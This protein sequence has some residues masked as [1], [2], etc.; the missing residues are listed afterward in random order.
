MPE[1]RPA[2][3]L[4]VDDTEPARYA[5]ART[6]QRAGF[7][8]VEAG[9]GEEALRQ[10]AEGGIDAVVLDI[11]LPDIS[12]LEVCRTIKRDHPDIM[13]LQLSAT[14]VSSGDRIKGLDS[15]AD[16]YLGQPVEPAELVATL[17]ALMRIRAAEAAVRLSE[18]RFRAIAETMPQVVWSARPNGTYEYFNSRWYAYTGMPPGTL[19][20]AAARQGW[21]AAVQTDDQARV[22]NSWLHSLASGEPFEMECRLRSGDGSYRWFLARALP[23]HNEAGAIIRWFGTCTDIEDIINAREVLARSQTE[24][25][26]MVAVRTREIAE[27]NERLRH[28]RA[29][30]ELLVASSADGIIAYDDDLR[31]T[32]WNKAMER[33]SGLSASNALGRTVGDLLP[34]LR[35]EPEQAMRRVLQGETA[36]MRD[37][38]YTFADSGREGWLEADCTP[39]RATNGEIIG[40][41]A[42]IRDITERR[43][44][45]EQL[46]QTQKL[47]ALG[48]LTSG[49]AHDFNNLLS[50]ILGNLDLIRKHLPAS[51]SD[52]T[53]LLDLA[54]QGAE[55]GQ[56]LT[57]RLL[58]FARRQDLRPG[59]VDIPQLLVG[60]RELIQRSIGPTITIEL[61]LADDLEPACV[62]ANQLELAIL[63]LA[64]NSRDAMPAGGAL[65]I[66]A[67]N[68]VVG[69]REQLAPSPGHYVCLSITDNGTGM[70]E[71]TMARA[72]D[73]FFTTKG[74]GKGTGLGL[75]MVHG[76][77][78]QSGGFLR[79]HSRIGVG[80]TVEIL[81][82]RAV[83]RRPRRVD[84]EQMPAM[85]SGRLTVLL[86]EDDWLIALSTQAMIE[87]LGHVV[88]TATSA[89]K[90][91]DLLRSGPTF[92][93]VLT[94]QAMPGMTGVEL[95]G[96]IRRQWP[97]LPV[98]L[99]TGY[100]ELPM[101]SA[102]E[103][104]RL[105]KPFRQDDLAAAIYQLMQQVQTK[106]R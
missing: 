16:Y 51:N 83:V 105:A 17:G 35:G 79:L 68:L 42:F 70:D 13:V 67:D 31:Y 34:F 93:L 75:S 91:L 30:S 15:G 19:S 20:T 84:S 18:A 65:V 22:T 62:D 72:V 28:E 89:T 9:S 50:A 97:G 104:P 41:I 73:P 21:C 76:L 43:A 101:L 53:H 49:V 86:V 106:R 29:F 48:Q 92:D 103:L 26:A 78:A 56:T 14:F 11:K 25:E 60:M 7:T 69:D 99:A 58:A 90:A 2:R 95:A 54:L 33:I 40:A 88:H 80:T 39:L 96:H 4:V 12:G 36:H 32:L 94:D 44:V 5:T 52:L 27:A 6:L 85:K 100:A 77:A 63:N 3:V 74:P 1:T 23:I 82:P 24:L 55:R 61:R 10:I 98:L 81:L 38:R 37:Q 57:Q 102:A 45:E 64:V 71:K 46:R 59:L 87:D 66:A 47:E 8:V